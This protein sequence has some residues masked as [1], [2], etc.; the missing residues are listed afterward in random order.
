[1]TLSN[2]CKIYEGDSTLQFLTQQ[3][4]SIVL[5]RMRL[6]HP[7][8]WVM[9][10]KSPDPH[11]AALSRTCVLLVWLF[12]Y[13]KNQERSHVAKNAIITALLVLFRCPSIT[14]LS[15]NDHWELTAKS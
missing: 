15:P 6:A 12:G 9:G 5:C 4:T 11:L 7:Q 10:T 1:M 3:H 14:S 2:L 8:V 13:E